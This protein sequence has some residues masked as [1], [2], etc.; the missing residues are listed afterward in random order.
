M[1][2]TLRNIVIAPTHSLFTHMLKSSAIKGWETYP[3]QEPIGPGVSPLTQSPVPDEHISL[4]V[5]SFLT[6][7]DGHRRVPEKIHKPEIW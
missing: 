3:Q 1:K 6:I 4:S 7:F 5:A 2:K